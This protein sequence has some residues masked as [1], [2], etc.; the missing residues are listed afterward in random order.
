MNNLT[1]SDEHATLTLRC[2]HHYKKS[3]F[4]SFYL[5]IDRHR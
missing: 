5:S 3:T 4:N 2:V 1:I